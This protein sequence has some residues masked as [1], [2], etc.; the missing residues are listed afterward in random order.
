MHKTNILIV[1]GRQGVGLWKQIDAKGKAFL[2]YM[3]QQA[4][5]RGLLLES[6]DEL[7]MLQKAPP[8]QLKFILLFS[9][10]HCRPL[11]QVLS[12]FLHGKADDVILFVKFYP[13]YQTRRTEQHLLAHNQYNPQKLSLL[14]P[15]G[16]LIILLIQND[17]FNRKS[18]DKLE[19]IPQYFL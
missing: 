8:F 16:Q 1:S 11:N 13:K 7:L 5:L 4:I 14:G 17:I 19:L 18:A 15:V 10:A 3:K 6:F 9:E 2:L 12:N